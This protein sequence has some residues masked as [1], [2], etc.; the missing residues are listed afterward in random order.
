M[1]SR[2]VT[3]GERGV[4]DVFAGAD[5]GEPRSTAEVAAALGVEDPRAAALLRASVE[6]GR[7]RSKELPDGGRV[8]WRPL[9][10]AASPADHALVEVE[11]R[12]A[13]LSAPFLAAFEAVEPAGELVPD[14]AEI[15]ATVDSVVSLRDGVLQ[16]YTARGV[17]PGRYLAALR[18]IP[19]V[20]GVRLL[21]TD[22]D[23]VRVEVRLEADDLADLFRAFGGWVTGGALLGSE[24]R[25]RGAVP[26]ETDVREVTAAVREWVPDAELVRRRTVHSPRI[27]RAILTECLSTQQLAALEAAYYGGYFAVPR[28]STGDEIAASLGVTRQTFNH[29]LRLAELAVVR[30][31]FRVTE[32]D[33]L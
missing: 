23:E 5:P 25:I 33:A 2:D 15:V 22:G 28:E 16:Y 17:S 31:L 9:G 24:I 19:G 32:D 6:A 11:Y 29:H 10:G 20:S 1:A 30:E 27:V 8:W 26:G 18:R 21:S 3:G 13:S 7:L 12:S 14:D 4:E